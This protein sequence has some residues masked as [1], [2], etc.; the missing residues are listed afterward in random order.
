MLHSGKQS[1]YGIQGGTGSKQRTEEKPEQEASLL[2]E[3]GLI[4]VLAP[5]RI[6]IGRGV[7]AA[8]SP[9]ELERLN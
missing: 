2:S 9:R 3:V 6:L 5:S 8:P 7:C 4:Q 1:P